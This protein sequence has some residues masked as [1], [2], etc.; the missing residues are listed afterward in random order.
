MKSNVKRRHEGAD[1]KCRVG[2]ES[3]KIM[4]RRDLKGLM[5][6]VF[7]YVTQCWLVVGHQSRLRNLSEERRH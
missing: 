7:L 2:G 3:W 1:E 4:G 5:S 6:L